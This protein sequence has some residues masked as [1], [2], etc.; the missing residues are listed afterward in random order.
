MPS[1]VHRRLSLGSQPAQEEVRANEK[2]QWYMT[3]L[4]G[5]V[6]GTVSKA[7]EN[8]GCS[9]CVLQSQ[10]ALGSLPV[11]CIHKR[12]SLDVHSGLCGARRLWVYSILICGLWACCSQ[13]GGLGD[14]S[15]G[16]EA[17]GIDR[18]HKGQ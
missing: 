8:C 3:V 16:S 14:A 10:T 13:C 15:E 9:Q 17:V 12:R 6:S 5:E 2:L 4:Q 1:S 18:G 11:G 7:M